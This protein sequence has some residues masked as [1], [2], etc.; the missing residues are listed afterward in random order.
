ELVDGG[1]ADAE[2]RGDGLRLVALAQPG[3]GLVSRDRVESCHDGAPSYR[4]RSPNGGPGAHGTRWA[5]RCKAPFG[6]AFSSAAS[7]TSLRSCD[8]PNISESA[9]V[10]S[11]VPRVLPLYSTAW[12]RY[13]VTALNAPHAVPRIP[14]RF[15]LV[16]YSS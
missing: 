8:R 7:A 1:G 16:W 2:L 12:S 9:R 14:S 10:S 6:Y 15:G 5:G 3:D 11:A 13:S 4:G